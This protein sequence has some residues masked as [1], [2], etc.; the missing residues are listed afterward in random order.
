MEEGLWRWARNEQ[1]IEWNV[2]DLGTS[3]GGLGL[4]EKRKGHDSAE[5]PWRWKNAYGDGHEKSTPSSS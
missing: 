3:L 1:A 2:V 4:E 5:V